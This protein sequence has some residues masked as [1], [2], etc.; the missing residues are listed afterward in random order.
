MTRCPDCHAVL[1][2][3]YW[4]R[5]RGSADAWRVV[6]QCARCGRI[7]EEPLPVAWPAPKVARELETR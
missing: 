4:T 1:P 3:L 7:I 2:S 6:Y 5:R